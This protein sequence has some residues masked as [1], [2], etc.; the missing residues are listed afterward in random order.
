LAIDAEYSYAEQSVKSK[1]KERYTTTIELY[2]KFIDKYPNSEFLRKAEILY[3]DSREKKIKL[4][5]NS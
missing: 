1:Q 2:E 3:V 4:S 5:N